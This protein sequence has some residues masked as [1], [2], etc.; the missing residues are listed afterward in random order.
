MVYG[1]ILGAAESLI[2]MFRSVLVDW[3][4]KTVHEP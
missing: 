4:S 2:V 3:S 1:T